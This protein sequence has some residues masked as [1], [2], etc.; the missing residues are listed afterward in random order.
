MMYGFEYFR[1]YSRPSRAGTVARR[2]RSLI[3]LL[4]VGHGIAAESPPG[5]AALFN[6]VN[7]EGWRGGA[8]FDQRRF[9][10]L[11]SEERAQQVAAWNAAL[12]AKGATGQPHWRVERNELV[13]D[14]EGGFATTLRDYGDL[15]FR[16]ECISATPMASPLALRGVPLALAVGRASEWNRIR[17]ILVGSRVSAWVND[18]LVLDHGVLENIHDRARPAGERR[19]VPPKGPLQLEG[20]GGATRW[21]NLFLREIGSD[22]ACA[23]LEGRGGHGFRTIFNGRNLDGWAGDLNAVAAQ[24]G[25]L[26]WQ[27]GQKGTVY[28][29]HPLADFGARVQFIVPA[30]GNNGL[31]IRY[32]GQGIPAYDG[33]AEIQLRDD[34]AT[35]LDKDPR[36]AHGSVYGMIPA[37][38]GYQHPLGEWN[39][40]EVTVKGSRILVELN[41]TVILDGDVAAVDPQTVLANHPHPGK[42]RATGFFG[43]AGH[44]DPFRFRNIMIREL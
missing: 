40:Q 36:Q 38:R 28:W 34:P 12:I 27:A 9:M 19:P 30:G 17:I 22:E 35:P 8:R 4:L 33:M 25:T 14:G 15:E 11:S 2:F 29:N 39:F 31:A 44:M 41:G 13:N 24:D 20:S 3:T 26:V 6:G 23:L 21:R 32:P 10:E 7:L 5:F 37:V 1:P 18:Q 16:G 42:D 43:F